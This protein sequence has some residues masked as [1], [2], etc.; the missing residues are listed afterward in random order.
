M[1]LKNVRKKKAKSCLKFAEFSPFYFNRP[2]DKSRLKLLIQWSF[3]VLGEKKTVELVELLKNVGYDYAT[4]AGISLTLDD[5]NIPPKKQTLLQQAHRNLKHSQEDVEKGQLTSVEYL[6]QILDKWNATSEL[7]KE[8]VI[9][10]FQARDILNPVYMMAFSGARGNISQVR[11]LTGMRG[12]MADPSGKIINF[13][14]QSN[15]REGMTLTE[16]MISCYGARKGVVDTA[17][18]TATSGYLTRR[19]V[20]SAHHVCIRNFDCGTHKGIFL[21]ELKSGKKTILHL[22]ERLIGRVL[23]TSIYDAQ[24][25]PVAA[26][27][28]EI[29]HGLATKIK[30]YHKQILV[31]SPLTCDDGRFVCQRCY[32]WSLA[33]NRLVSIGESVGIIA[34]QSIGE[35]GTQLTMRTFH[36]G[37]VF[38]GAVADELRAPFNGQVYFSQ[39]VAGLCVRTTHG[40]IAFLTKQKS[41]FELRGFEKN[42]RYTISLEPFSLIFVKQKQYVFENQPLAETSVNEKLDQT[43]TVF[44]TVTS[45]FSGEIRFRQAAFIHSFLKPF[46]LFKNSFLEKNKF[47]KFRLKKYQQRSV[48]PHITMQATEF[49]I[50][51]SHRQRF[52]ETFKELI[53]KP[54]DQLDFQAPIQQVKQ[55]SF[56]QLFQASRALQPHFKL[57]LFAKMLV[58]PTLPNQVF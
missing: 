41:S 53:I 42:K 57:N 22:Q 7:L 56:K 23:A 21:N 46:R 50:L 28:E 35:P 2:F 25:N 54:G 37:G 27:N 13:P 15:F 43:K 18:R 34:A 52:W 20:D 4:K 3:N 49:W 45:P 30:A 33:V 32:G 12:L 24:K 44:Q 40:K 36:T 8:A 19:L 14:I 55:N 38:S 9:E 29:S 51:A 6:T 11:Q 58:S 5:L 10:N 47:K 39:A 31:R 16:Y 48:T 1:H 17:L 26:R